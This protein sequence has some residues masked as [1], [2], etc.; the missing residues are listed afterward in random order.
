[1]TLRKEAIF[2]AKGIVGHVDLPV[3]VFFKGY[4][5]DAVILRIS[6]FGHSLEVTIGCPAQTLQCPAMGGGGVRGVMVGE[7]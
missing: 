4:F 7:E 1:M 5:D 6:L 3:M 2:L